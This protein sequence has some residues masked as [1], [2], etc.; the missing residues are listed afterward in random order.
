MKSFWQKLD[1]YFEEFCCAAMLGYIAISLNVEVIARYV[2]NSPSAYT[3]EIARILMT[4][5]VFLGTSLAIKQERHVIIDLFPDLSK[6]QSLILNLISNIIFIIFCVIFIFVAGRAVFFHKMLGT[7][8]EGL[9]LPYWMVLLMLPVSFS[10]SI[11]R[12]CQKIY[13]L[14]KNYR[15]SL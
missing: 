5:I 15:E 13:F 7:N 3:D 8:T 9:G 1:S 4:G 14:I 11:L 12:L 10:L 2:F 6:K